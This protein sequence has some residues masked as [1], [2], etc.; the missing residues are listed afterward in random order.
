M[1]CP[2]KFIRLLRMGVG[3]ALG[4]LGC[5][6]AH[7]AVQLKEVGTRIRVERLSGEGDRVEHDLWWD[8]ADGF[9]DSPRVL[10][11]IGTGAAGRATAQSRVVL[12]G[13]SEFFAAFRTTASAE[14]TAP[15]AEMEFSEYASRAMDASALG[16]VRIECRFETEGWLCIRGQGSFAEA[17]GEGRS[18][19]A[20]AALILDA[21]GGVVAQGIAEGHAG[22]WS[23]GIDMPAAA[24]D[25]EVQLEWRGDSLAESFTGAS[26]SGVGG[27]VSV[28]AL[29]G[30]RPRCRG[31]ADGN[32]TV[33]FHD[34][35]AVLQ[36]YGRDYGG[37]PS[38]GDSNLDGHVDFGDITA[39]I[40]NLALLCP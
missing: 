18:E 39:I 13:G 14:A 27:T 15:E 35:V 25:Y 20:F 22:V 31:D 32:G 28:H 24:G 1:T 40:E 33:S 29:A 3:F 38:A 23:V 19:S 26:A 30:P 12:T 9:T 34:L 10:V 17:D 7:A 11:T 6:C 37:L 16:R 5:D 2:R 36:Y 8:C 4:G 21:Y